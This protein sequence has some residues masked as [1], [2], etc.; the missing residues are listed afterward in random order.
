MKKIIIFGVAVV[1][2]FGALAFVTSYQNQQQSEGNPY[3]KDRL[4]QETIDTLDDPNYDNIILPDELDEKIENEEDFTVYYFSPACQACNQVSP[5]I[6]PMAD[7]KDIDLHLFN[8]LEFD[9]GF[10]QFGIDGTPT[11]IHYE[12][13]EEVER[14]YGAADQPTYEWFYDDIVLGEE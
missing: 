14:I 12:N 6:I 7:E 10:S 2:I 11:L 1:I 5:V 3:G 9:N 4:H 8:L 13:G